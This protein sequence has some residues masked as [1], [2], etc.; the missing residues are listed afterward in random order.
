MTYLMQVFPFILLAVAL[1]LAAFFTLAPFLPFIAYWFTP[2]A[3]IARL[4]RKAQKIAARNNYT[5]A[6][7]T[8]STQAHEFE[9]M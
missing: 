3:R 2:Q 8:F 6:S 9:R 4:L 1:F 7:S 5:V